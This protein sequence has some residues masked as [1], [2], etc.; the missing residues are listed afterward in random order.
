M[1][2]LVL[3]GLAALAI[4]LARR[5]VAPPR[6]ASAFGLPLALGVVFPALTATGLFALALV[7]YFLYLVL[8][9]RWP[10]YA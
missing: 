7:V 2:L 8:G 4:A 6:L 9:E 3:G 10:P 1:L 5:R